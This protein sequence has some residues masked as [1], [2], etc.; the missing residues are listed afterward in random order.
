MHFLL[1]GAFRLVITLAIM[2]TIGVSL[3]EYLGNLEDNECSMTY[4]KQNPGIIPVDL[5]EP[6]RRKFSN[7]K[8]YFYCE[9]YDCQKYESLR[10][11]EPN[12]GKHSFLSVGNQ[13]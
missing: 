2:I 8:L 11:N 4:M 1:S 7:Y 10:F 3:F 6:I 12:H 5:P 13:L 9:G